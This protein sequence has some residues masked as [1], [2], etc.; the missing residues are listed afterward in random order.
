M[1]PGSGWIQGL[2][3]SRVWVGPGS[4]CIQGL[5]GFRV[6]VDSGSEWSQGLGGSR[7]WV[8][9]GSG[10]IQGLGGARV[11]VDPGSGWIQG[12]GGSRV[13]V[14]PG[15][16]WIQGLGGSW[17]WVDPGFGWVQGLVRTVLSS[18]SALCQTKNQS[19]SKTFLANVGIRPL[20]P[21]SPLALR[22]RNILLN[23][24]VTFSWC[25]CPQSN[26]RLGM[27]QIGSSP[28]PLICQGPDQTGP[29][30]P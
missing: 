17:V 15:S 6:W 24:K 26:S 12:L 30:S 28:G 5:S 4:G 18:R 7:V 3:G 13:W 10:W 9:P 25:L 19:K 20:V 21:H 1:D 23:C 2:G 16:E 27:I 22:R 14:E 29:P 11:W 8:D